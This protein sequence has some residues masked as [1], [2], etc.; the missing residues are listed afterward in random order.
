MTSWGDAQDET[1][2]GSGHCLVGGTLLPPVLMSMGLQGPAKVLYWLYGLNCH[3]LPQR[4]YFLFG[5]D[6]VNTYS[7]EQVVD[8]GADPAHL[9][10][11][12]GNARM[13]FKLG[14]AQRNTAIYTTVF[15]AG[16]AY[17]LVR[18]RRPRLRWPLGRHCRGFYLSTA[19][20]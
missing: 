18:R 11:F 15:V 7:L 5:P 2:S 6:G 3:Q 16:V 10:G 1:Y 14:M 19:S 9:R 4:S 17:G 12:V 8:W 13:G 20:S